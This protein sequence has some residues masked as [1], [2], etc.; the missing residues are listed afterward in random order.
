MQISAAEITSWI[1]SFVWPFLRI[2]AMFL[3][4]P[5]FSGRTLPARVR[6]VIVL[7]ITWVIAFT[8]PPA[9]I[10]E[11]LSL[12]GLLVAIHQV[13]IGMVMGFAL[14]LV[15]S[16]VVFGGQVIAYSMGLGFASMVDPANGVQVPVVGQY[17]VL[18]TTLVFLALDGHLVLIEL[19]ADSFR[20]LPV[21][22]DGITRNGLWA[23]VGWTTRMFEGGLLLALPAVVALLLVNITFGVVTRAAPQLNIFAVGFP[24]SM[25]LGFWILWAAL[26][27]T[28]EQF[29]ELLAAAFE[30]LRLLLA[31]GP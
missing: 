1:G 31:G 20:T 12:V 3:V 9:P 29:E 19:V 22:P 6:L 26:P 10:A 24:V 7:A 8:L 2:G 11:P 27:N 21:A 17:F 14:Q 18:L 25:L 4:L 16:A 23:L 15:F 28:L 13:L 5:I 30:L